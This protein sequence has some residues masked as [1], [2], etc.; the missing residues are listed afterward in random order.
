MSRTMKSLADSQ[1]DCEYHVVFI[2]KYRRTAIYGEL[3]NMLVEIFHDVAPQKECRIIEGHE[4]S[5]YVDLCLEIPPTQ[6]AA[7]VVGFLKGKSALAI[8]RRV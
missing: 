6:A 4:L 2:P 5:D 8:A 1:S 3:R 7:S